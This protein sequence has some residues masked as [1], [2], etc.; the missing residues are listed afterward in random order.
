ML[1]AEGLGVGL[2]RVRGGFSPIS[3]PNTCQVVAEGLG[4]FA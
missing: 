4:L 3:R 2:A 1:I